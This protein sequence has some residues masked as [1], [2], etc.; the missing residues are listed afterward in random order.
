PTTPVPTTPVPTTPVPTTPVP[1]T[2]VPTTPVLTKLSSEQDIINAVNN[3]RATNDLPGLVENPCLSEAL[4]GAIDCGPGSSDY[5]D[6]NDDMAIMNSIFENNG[7]Y[8]LKSTVSAVG[9]AQGIGGV[10]WKSFANTAWGGVGTT[11]QQFA[12][13]LGSLLPTQSEG[14][15]FKGTDLAQIGVATKYC[16]S[17]GNWYFDIR[18]IPDDVLFCPAIDGPS[19]EPGP[20]TR[21]CVDYVITSISVPDY[22]DPCKD[23]LPVT[24]TIT[25]EGQTDI[26]TSN[27]GVE[28]WLGGTRYLQPAGESSF[29]PLRGGESVTL[30][31]NFALP[32]DIGS[33]TKSV[34]IQINSWNEEQS[35]RNYQVHAYHGN[36]ESSQNFILLPC[37]MTEKE[38]KE[39]TSPP[40]V[41]RK[42][43]V[44]GGG[45]HHHH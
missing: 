2:P 26:G 17:T 11:K 44:S 43:G 41:E 27:I 30:T 28:G 25:N 24:L 16:P 1:T 8:S 37:G 3:F 18:A 40:P 4:A 9:I 29:V 13:Y 32:D 22:I 19:P 12:N 39:K 6:T 14:T 21:G 20:V 10:H 31:V 35:C 45:G 36:E 23:D 34:S 38:Y 7:G 33:A 15:L 42:S 5:T